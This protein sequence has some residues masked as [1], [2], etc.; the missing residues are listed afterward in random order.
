MDA[1]RSSKTDFRMD[2]QGASN[3]FEFFL[4]S[5]GIILSCGSGPTP[6][7]AE[8]DVF[9]SLLNCVL[10]SDYCMITPIRTRY[11]EKEVLRLFETAD[12]APSGAFRYDLLCD[13]KLLPRSLLPVCEH[14]KTI[15]HTLH[16]CRMVSSEMEMEAAS[17]ISHQSLTASSNRV[18]SASP[19]PLDEGIS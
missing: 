17:M 2:M 11:P 15:G 12:E 13:H 4:I 14:C 19:V 10:K 9:R 16:F 3:G 7:N 18:R 6:S 1:F 5:E 8:A